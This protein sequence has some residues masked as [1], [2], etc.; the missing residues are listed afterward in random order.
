MRVAQPAKKNRD[1]SGFELINQVLKPKAYNIG[2]QVKMRPLLTVM[3]GNDEL[4]AVRT[5]IRA[6]VV[7]GI[8]A[9]APAATIFESEINTSR[10]NFWPGCSNLFC[11]LES[12][13]TPY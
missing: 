13:S 10:R 9:E 12:W 2:G 3:E 1:M 7:P 5:I 11:S 8:S 4:A 6:G